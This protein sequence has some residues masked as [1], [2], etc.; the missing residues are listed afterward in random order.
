MLRWLLFKMASPFSRH[1]FQHVKRELRV[2]VF[3]CMKVAYK[4]G[5]LTVSYSFLTL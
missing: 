4:A 1:N 5:H 2:L 3:A